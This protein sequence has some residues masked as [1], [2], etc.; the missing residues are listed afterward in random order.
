M[1]LRAKIVRKLLR[2]YIKLSTGK[3]INYRGIRLYLD[4]VFNPKR[5]YSTDL[6]VEHLHEKTFNELVEVGSGSGALIISLADKINYGI[7]T[8][9]VW[10][11]ACC[12]KQNIVCAKYSHKIDVIVAD[13][14]S[15]FRASSL[16][17]VV[18]N[19]PYLPLDP[20]DEI[21]L[22]ICCGRKLELFYKFIEELSEKLKKGGEAYITCSSLTG[23]EKVLS[24]VKDFGFTCSIEGVKKTIFDKIFLL[25]I[26]R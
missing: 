21:D 11:T 6:L 5:T 1:S 24:I 17:V 9:V 4:S 23:L 19:P 16:N 10:R 8:D 14:L 13:G 18:F 22:A 7:A 26:S 2:A 15:C 3:Y 20:L 12:A 25:K